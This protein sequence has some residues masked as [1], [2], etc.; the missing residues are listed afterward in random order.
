MP[1]ARAVIRKA[2][3]TILDEEKSHREALIEC[4]RRKRELNECLDEL[5]PVMSTSASQSFR[6][7]A[8]ALEPKP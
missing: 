4:A 3:K 2:V 7:A 5:T 8:A 1:D 6:A